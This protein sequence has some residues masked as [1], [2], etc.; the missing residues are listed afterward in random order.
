[1]GSGS[2]LIFSMRLWHVAKLPEDFPGVCFIDMS[3]SPG[4]VLVLGVLGSLLIPNSFRLD[5]RNCWPESEDVLSAGKQPFCLLPATA[6]AIRACDKP[7]GP[8]RRFIAP[9]IAKP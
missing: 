9:F 8:T 4:A 6:V 7:S 1:M 3:T 2:S 5:V